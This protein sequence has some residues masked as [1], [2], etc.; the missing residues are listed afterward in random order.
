MTVP[1]RS[2]LRGGPSRRG[3]DVLDDLFAVVAVYGMEQLAALLPAAAQHVDFC[4][5]EDALL[6]L[7]LEH[8]PRR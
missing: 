3:D 6:D 1:S 7:R 8:V 2:P 4:W 5:G